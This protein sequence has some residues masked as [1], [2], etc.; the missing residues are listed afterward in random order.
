MHRRGSSTDRIVAGDEVQDRRCTS[1]GFDRKIG[2][3]TSYQLYDWKE[4]REVDY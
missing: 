3:E 2:N 4:C 1:A